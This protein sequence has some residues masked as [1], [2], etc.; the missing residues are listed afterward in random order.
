MPFKKSIS[1]TLIL[2]L[3]VLSCEYKAPTSLWDP[4]REG[5]PIPVITAVDPPLSA[6]SGVTKIEISGQH[7]GAAPE[8]NTVYFDLLKGQILTASEGRLTVV[9]PKLVG[10]SLTIKVV[11]HSAFQPAL[12]KPYK[13]EAAY[14]DIIEEEQVYSLAIDCD[15]NLYIHARGRVI[16]KLTP[17]GD[18]S[19]YGSVDF[20][21][22]SCMRFGPAQA[23]FI[24]KLD[25]RSLF[26]MPA[27][28]GESE[29]F[30]RFPRK[31]NFFDFDQNGNIYAGGNRTGIYVVD[32]GGNVTTV[33]YYDE[34]DI[35][36]V[37]VY[38]GC[39]Y[40]AV[41]GEK[42]GIWKNEILTE[43]GALGEAVE[44]F[45]WANSG[46]FSASDPLDM[47]FSLEGE[48]VVGT[49]RNEEAADEENR[50]DPILIIGN[51][52]SIETLYTG[53]IRSPAVC[54]CWGNGQ[55]LYVSRLTS[56]RSNSGVSQVSM[57]KSG[58]PYYGRGC[59]P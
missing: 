2:L 50:F 25:D 26:R 45:D 48:I 5:T 18:L 59:P 46:D 22:S 58:A 54:L 49:N 3:A 29:E 13:L 47:T 57:G 24:Q 16:N 56:G 12:Y 38:D 28:G 51:D 7:F 33:D 43:A 10:D 37:R 27:G 39:V 53:L 17:E 23:L 42:T 35:R 30:V 20:I 55:Y 36:S 52:G 19:E 6:L 32:P 41:S 21:Y 31:T 34:S 15:E 9:P 14:L 44:V 8:L 11:V 40:V 1:G 4:D